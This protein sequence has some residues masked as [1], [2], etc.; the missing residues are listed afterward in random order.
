MSDND[1][2]KWIEDAIANE[3]FKYYE[4]KYF[5][6]I[7]VGVGSFGKVYRANWRKHKCVALKSFFNLDNATVK[8][9][10]HEVTV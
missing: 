8:E 1:W 2:N 10:V 9:I 7:Q 6:N 3:Y 4:Y 5:S